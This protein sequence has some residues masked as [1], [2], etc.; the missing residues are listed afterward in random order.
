MDALHDIYIIRYSRDE[1]FK[2]VEFLMHTLLLADK[3]RLSHFYFGII[4]ISLYALR[5]SP[6]KSIA[7]MISVV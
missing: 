6:R 3:Y 2:S 4:K 7:P 5:I 1:D